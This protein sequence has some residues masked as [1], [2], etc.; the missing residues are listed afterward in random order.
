MS[1]S[2][3]HASINDENTWMTDT[4]LFSR[5]CVYY[6]YHCGE[7]LR[8]AVTTMC[9]E[10]C[11]PLDLI[12]KNVAGAVAAR[13]LLRTKFGKQTAWPFA[14]NSD[15]QCSLGRQVETE[16]KNTS[17]WPMDVCPTRPLASAKLQ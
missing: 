13:T 7:T 9:Q 6:D 8:E 5:V 10:K 3:S 16:A 2:V 11:Y 4:F 1:S 14:I 17:R 12:L 15:Y